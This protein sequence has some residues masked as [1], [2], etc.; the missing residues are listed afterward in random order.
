MKIPVQEIAPVRNI[1]LGFLQE[2]HDIEDV[3]KCVE[4]IDNLL[5]T[6]PTIKDVPS[7]VLALAMQFLT[8]TTLSLMTGD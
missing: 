5:V 1:L 3:G 2:E 7:G 8:D 6:C 4:L